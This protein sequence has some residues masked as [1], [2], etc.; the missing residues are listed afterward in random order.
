MRDVPA[1]PPETLRRARSIAK[2]EGLAHVYTGNVHDADGDTTFCTGCD[3]KLI[4]RD[5]YEL[6]AVR[7]TP[8][9]RCLACGTELA[10]RFDGDRE[11]WGRRRLPVRIVA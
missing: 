10:G 2:S 6:L 11:R 4:E 7:L 3:A 1:T 9:G 8:E 5:W